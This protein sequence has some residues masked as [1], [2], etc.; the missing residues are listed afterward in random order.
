[1]KKLLFAILALFAS[2]V[3]AKAVPATP[4]PFQ[5]IQPD[6]SVVTIHVHGDEFYH[7]LTCNGQVVIIGKDGFIHPASKPV[8]DKDLILQKRARMAVHGRGAAAGRRE[9]D[10]LSLGDKHF[11]VLLIEFDDLKFTVP[12]ANDAFSRMLNAEGYSDNGGTGSVA[13]YY[14]ENSNGKFRPV[15]DVFGPVKVSKSYSYYGENDENGYDKYPD[16]LLLEACT[17]LDDQVD[18]SIYDHDNDKYIDN[19]FFYFAGHNEAEGADEAHI[20]PHASAAYDRNR[21]FDGKYTWS[22]A[23]TSEYGGHSG[24]NMAGIGTFCHEFAHVLEL[25]D[26]YDT[27]YEDNGSAKNMYA[28]SLMCEGNYNNNGRTPPYLGALER[29]LLGWMDTVNTTSTPGDYVLKPVQEDDCLSTPTS[30]DG[31]YFIYEVRNGQGWDSY[32]RT[33]TTSKPPHGMLIYHVDMSDSPVAGTTAKK[34]WDKNELNCYSEHPCCY[35]VSPKNSYSDYN[36]MLWPGTSGNTNFE[37]SEWAGGRTGMLLSGIAWNGD[38]MSFKLDIPTE[39]ILRGKV[40]DSSGQ[41]LSGVWVSVDTQTVNTGADGGFSFTFPANYKGDSE[42]SFTKEMYRPVKRRLGILAVE[43]VMDVTM[44]SIFE[45]EPITLSKHGPSSDMGLG[46]QVEGSSWSGTIGV[47]YTSE[48]LEAYVGS[49]FQKINF[50][51]GGK[52][53]VKVDVF[54]DFGSNRAYTKTIGTFNDNAVTTVDISDAKLTVPEGEDVIFGVSV[55]DIDTQYWMAFDKLEA[56][57][58]GGLMWADYT[59]EGHPYSLW[60]EPAYNFLIDCEIGLGGS[61]YEAMAFY[62]LSNPRKGNAYPAGS[63]LSLALDGIG[64]PV[65]SVEWFFDGARISDN[66]V[67]LSAAGSH[68]LKA[69]LKYTDGSTEEIEQGIEVK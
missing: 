13:D 42:I 7:Y 2:V 23:C 30:V 5:H 60:I 31:E 10:R 67:T 36:D 58:G 17:Q 54:V 1:M 64:E 26:F 6:G 14:R 55:K 33:K 4:H 35:I 12:N 28:F 63:V 34:L 18:F 68:T 50:Q 21:V 39:R 29:W 15:F 40:S 61:A 49:V 20:W 3:I 66:T 25:P 48:E 59:Q 37:G 8:P 56:V 43:T 53:A 45:N 57:P 52:S 24:N 32:I 51:I 38:N 46:F 22:Y 62:T 11:L 19:I 16:E 27:D 44:R 65:Q 9:K 41:P 69:V 47:R